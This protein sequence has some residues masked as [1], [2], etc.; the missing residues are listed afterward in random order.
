M[1][2]MLTT[3]PAAAARDAPLWEAGF[4][5]AGLA[6]PDYRGSSHS[7][8]W[9]LPAPYFIYRGDFIKSD[10]EGM[11][12]SF[13]RNRDVDLNLSVGASLPVASDRNPERE[14]MPDLKPSLEV[15][16]ALDITLWRAA[17]ERL[18]LDLRLPLRAAFTVESSPR[19][20]GTQFFPNVNLDV[21]E[22]LGF[23][24][25]KV[26]MLGGAVFNDGR[27]N[28]RFYEVKPEFATAGRPAFA[29][30]GGG[31]GGFEFIVALSKRYPSF[32][33]GGFARYDTL[34]GAVFEDSP[35]V[36]SKHYV[37]GGIAITWI[38]K[39]S[40]TR[41]PVNEFGEEVRR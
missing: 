15:G 5:I 25:W 32:W 16:P 12:G 24:G 20:A 38:F 39:E 27:Y 4:G 1:A 22:P 13:F 23:A 9:V 26:G 18:K 37:A 17:D 30:P 10:R 29:A 35:L 14:G 6:F 41:V 28:E 2:A 40:T 31:F 36:T 7:R 19:F 8:G 21:H 3:L 34:K 11:R 33:V